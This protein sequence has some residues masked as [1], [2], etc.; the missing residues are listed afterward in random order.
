MI[1]GSTSSF[2]TFCFNKV[3]ILHGLKTKST[4]FSCITYRSYNWL[5]HDKEQLESY[6]KHMAW[7]NFFVL[8]H[9]W[10]FISFTD[11]TF[12]IQRYYPCPSDL[13]YL[14]AVCVQTY[15]YRYLY[16][17]LLKIIKHRASCI[18]MCITSSKL[19]LK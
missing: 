7:E 16:I 8:E 12:I 6:K 15:A 14:W 11:L 3:Q 18:Y 2:R 1:Q 9:F 13:H 17:S 19:L 5:V 10:K 4:L